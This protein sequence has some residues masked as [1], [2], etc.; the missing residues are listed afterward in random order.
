MAVVLTPT[1]ATD[2]AAGEAVASMWR[3]LGARVVLLAPAAHDA[4]IAAVSH[5]P[6]VAAFALAGALADEAGSL[7]G[8]AGGSFD[9]GTRVAASAPA[10]WVEILLANRAALAPWVERF[11][12]RVEALRE[13]L[14]A[15]DAESLGAL[16]P[17]GGAASARVLGP[18]P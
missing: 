17:E 14:V 5:L 8:L 10:A 15:D 1:P 13:A 6:H 4:A 16:L 9:S 3:A 12:A 7:A 18:K 11:A 2:A